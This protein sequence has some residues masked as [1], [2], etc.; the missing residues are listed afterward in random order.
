MLVA[1]LST[2]EVNSTLAAELARQQGIA[3]RHLEPRDGLPGTEFD[4]VLCDWDYWHVPGRAGLLA[5]LSGGAAGRPVALH[6]YHVEP[7]QVEALRRGGVVL[8]PRLRA[9][10]FQQ[11]RQA[12]L[13]ARV[14]AAVGGPK[15]SPLAGEA[16]N[17][18]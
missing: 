18:A 10:V 14:A 8:H 9:K 15:T 6:G 12:V 17:A 4:A 1:Y 7:D 3:L 11:L 13:A 5:D 2:D 16:D